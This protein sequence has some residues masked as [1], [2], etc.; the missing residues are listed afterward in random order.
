MQNCVLAF[1]HFITTQIGPYFWSVAQLW[2]WI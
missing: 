2:Y 1:L